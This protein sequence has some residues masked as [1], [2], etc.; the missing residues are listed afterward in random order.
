[1]KNTVISSFPLAAH[2]IL[3]SEGSNDGRCST[4]HWEAPVFPSPTRLRQ[5]LISAADVEVVVVDGATHEL[6]GADEWPRAH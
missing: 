4:S 3:K 5:E 2:L 1:M 6:G